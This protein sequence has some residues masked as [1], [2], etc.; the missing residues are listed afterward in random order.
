MSGEI[1]GVSHSSAGDAEPVAC[2][3]RLN[4][5]SQWLSAA[6][7]SQ[8]KI[9][10]NDANHSVSSFDLGTL[11]RIAAEKTVCAVT[12]TSINLGIYAVDRAVETSLD[13]DGVLGTDEDSPSERR[14]AVVVG[15]RDLNVVCAIVVVPEYQ[16]LTTGSA[17]A[18]VL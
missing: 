5:N 10:F 11:I 1:N 4:L 2:K 13:A 18:L 12:F 14:F 15:D 8:L 6:H 9:A 3:T 16:T 7:A 17:C